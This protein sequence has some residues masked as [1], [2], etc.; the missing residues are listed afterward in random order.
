MRPPEYRSKEL[1][2]V[3]GATPHEF[4]SRILRHSR[5]RKTA[6]HTVVSALRE[7][8]TSRGGSLVWSRPG[9]VPSQLSP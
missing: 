1:E 5:S 2:S 6:G 4:E 9:V 3:L 8:D 7:D